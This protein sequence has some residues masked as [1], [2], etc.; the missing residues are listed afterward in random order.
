MYGERN[1]FRHHPPKKKLEHQNVKLCLHIM[2]HNTYLQNLLCPFK[3]ETTP[4]F[5]HVAQVCT[6]A[7]PIVLKYK[8]HV[9][10]ISTEVVFFNILAEDY[11]EQKSHLDKQI[12]QEQWSFP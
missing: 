9:N 10:K 12:Q 2:W 11:H 8:S 6:R 3:A 5:L 7:F 4:W 1:Y